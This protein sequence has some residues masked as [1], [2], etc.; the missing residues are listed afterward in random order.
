MYLHVLVILRV[1]SCP[2]DPPCVF[3]SLWLI[4]H[5]DNCNIYTQPP[6][7]IYVKI[8]TSA[9]ARSLRH[10][11]TSRKVA[12]SIGIFH[13]NNPSGR[14]LAVVSTQP[15]T[16]MSTKNIS[17]R[18]NAAGAYG[19]QTYY[20]LVLIVIKSPPPSW[21]LRTCPRLCRD[22]FA[23]TQLLPLFTVIP[24]Q[25]FSLQ[26][27][28]HVSLIIYL[29]LITLKTLRV[30]LCSL[31]FILFFTT[32]KMVRNIFFRLSVVRLMFSV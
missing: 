4:E 16:E 8:F 18:V 27:T 20:S 23:S 12:E 28:K 14:T 22:C 2:C 24:R 21:T 30:S 10:C 29:I 13:W 25:L 9:E 11:A 1:P 3:M 6:L 32:C 5:R 15:L 19:W 17:W 7:F 26:H 31:L